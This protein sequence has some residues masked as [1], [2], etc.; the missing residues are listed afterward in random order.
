[1]LKGLFS[2]VVVTAD[3]GAVKIYLQLNGLPCLF[4]LKTL[5]TDSLRTCK[6]HEGNYVADYYFT[7]TVHTTHCLVTLGTLSYCLR[8]FVVVCKWS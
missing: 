5:A 7:V 4:L 6:T 3:I 8:L 2:S 1:M